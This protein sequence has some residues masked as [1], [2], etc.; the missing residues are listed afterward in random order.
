MPI[1]NGV[2]LTPGGAF[3]PNIGATPEL[4]RRL[5]RTYG[6]KVAY[7]ARKSNIARRGD[8]PTM[9]QAAR[10]SG[11]IAQAGTQ[12]RRNLLTLAAKGWK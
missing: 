12:G 6:A 1:P 8:A 5:V 2:K 7:G 11:T 4:D 3:V 10:Y 9:Y